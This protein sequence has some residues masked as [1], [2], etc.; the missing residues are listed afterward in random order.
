MRNYCF[1]CAWRSRECPPEV[2]ILRLAFQALLVE[3]GSREYSTRDTWSPDISIFKSKCIFSTRPLVSRCV[4]HNDLQSNASYTNFKRDRDKNNKL[5]G[6][7]C[8]KKTTLLSPNW[9]HIIFYNVSKNISIC[10]DILKLVHFY[11]SVWFLGQT[12]QWP[13]F[14]IGI[15]HIYDFH[16]CMDM[17]CCE[18]SI[19]SWN[20][21]LLHV[22]SMHMHSVQT[23]VH[24]FS[25]FL[26]GPSLMFWMGV[27]ACV[28]CTVA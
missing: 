28:L 11:C 2:E 21:C 1:T 7:R 6:F 10:G 25:S 14:L 8:A 24:I 22:V 13:I 19:L 9:G 27:I 4:L 26:L 23:C 18:S 20:L 15:G 3:T 16:L 12:M 17:P 5:G